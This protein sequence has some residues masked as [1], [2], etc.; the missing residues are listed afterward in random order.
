MRRSILRTILI[1]AAVSLAL[2]MIGC[3]PVPAEEDPSKR[4]ENEEK[5][6]RTM[7]EYPGDG[8]YTPVMTHIGSG[9]DE[10]TEEEY[11][12]AQRKADEDKEKWRQAVGG[13]FAEGM[14][15]TFYPKWYR[16]YI[17]GIA[18][19]AGLTSEMTHY[20]IEDDDNSD[21][22]EHVIT[23]VVFADPYGHSLSYDLDWM[24][25]FDRQN[26]DLLQTIELMDDGGLWESIAEGEEAE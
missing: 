1:I 6:L 2:L 5:L 15:D 14:F 19:S 22:L 20:S 18:Y 7:I 12:E 16:E 26:H 10:L 8:L 3:R 11:A 13:C 9:A 4:A 17:V 21:N 23:T 24:V 25:K